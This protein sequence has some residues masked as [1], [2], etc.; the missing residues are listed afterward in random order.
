MSSSDIR[1]EKITHGRIGLSVKRCMIEQ[2]IRSQSAA[3]N[4][5][6]DQTRRRSHLTYA[7]LQRERNREA[8]R[9]QTIYLNFII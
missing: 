9:K 8:Q 3:V 1:C 2:G 5:E 7:S 6:Q 4:K